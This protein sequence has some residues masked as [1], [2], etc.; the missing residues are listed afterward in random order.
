MREVRPREMRPEGLALLV[1]LKA[2]E[3][4]GGPEELIRRR[5]LTWVPTL[6]AAA[7]AV[8]LREQWARTDEEIARELGTTVQTVRHMLRAD[9]D[10]VQ[11]RLEEPMPEDEASRD[12]IA[13]GLA[14]L[15]YRRLRHGGERVALMDTLA[16]AQEM[17]R[18]EEAAVAM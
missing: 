12:H 14:K 16:E 3:L 2:L 9:P 13:G 6:M 4:A 11:A 10:R 8:V 1:F 18:A 5:H 7:Y 15:A 17:L